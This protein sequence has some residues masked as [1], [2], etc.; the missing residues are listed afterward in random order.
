MKNQ[1]SLLTQQSEGDQFKAGPPT[2]ALEVPSVP[3]EGPDPIMPEGLRVNRFNHHS[4]NTGQSMLLEEVIEEIRNPSPERIKLIGEIRLAYTAT[5]GGKPGK[6]AIRDLKAQLPAV[7]FSATGTRLNPEAATGIIAIDLDELG[8]KLGGARR[9]LEYDPHC[10]AVFLSPSGDGLKALIKVPTPIGTGEEM[11]L[12]HR[13][14]FLAVR[15]YIERG[16]GLSVDS[17]ASDLL[18][19]CYLSLDPGCRIVMSAETLD[20]A[21]HL[22][23]DEEDP[24]NRSDDPSAKDGRDLVARNNSEEVVQALLRSIPPFPDYLTWLKISAAVRNSLGDNARAVELLK[25]WSPE[26]Q[27]GEYQV[28]LASSSFSR[29]GFGT[30]VHHAREH[31]FEGVLTKCFYA[32]RSG[33]YLESGGSY[34]PLPRESDLKQ[35]LRLYGMNPNSPDCP[36]CR[37]RTERFMEFV[38]EVAGHRAGMHEFNGARFLVTKGPTIIESAEGD[39]N[40]IREFLMRLLGTEDEEQ[41]FCFLAWLHRART[42]VLAGQRTQIPALAVAGGVGDGKSLLIEIVR[43]SLG[44]RAANA[45]KYLSGQTRFNGNLVGAELMFVDDDAAAKDHNSRAQFAQFLKTT[46]FAG[47]VAAEGKGIDAVQCA[48]VQAVMIAVNSEPKHLRVLPELDDT[49]SDKII[50]LKSSPSPLPPDLAG[51]RGLIHARLLEDLPGFLHE[52]ENIDPSEWT[53]PQKGRLICYWNNDLVEML[54]MLSPEQ[55][56]LELIVNEIAP[57]GVGGDWEGTAAE[58]ESVLTGQMAKNANAARNILTWGNACGTYLANLAE[59]ADG[60][61]TKIELTRVS[62]IQRYKIRIPRAENEEGEEPQYHFNN[63]P[64]KEGY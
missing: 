31:G 26:K 55:R 14:N 58:L 40:F 5:G 25:D 18:R 52:I 59:K 27:V 9:Q 51:K 35:H 64:R 33:Y 48:P 56:L 34:I 63:I 6:A 19:L 43:L 28:L 36:T 21:R 46:L 61:V 23:S 7:T 60:I 42:A 20:V 15:H 49:M 13:K 8:G 24:D 37:I 47:S 29:I 4:A 16:L 1:S 12:A 54:N 11:R 50:L 22:P 38:G 44:G 10:M 30:L 39:G 57:H 62:R 2:F 45:H 17:A 32:G 53:N 41:Y 3:D